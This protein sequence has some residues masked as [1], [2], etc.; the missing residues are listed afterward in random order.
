MSTDLATLKDRVKAIDPRFDAVTI[1][2]NDGQRGVGDGV[3]SCWGGNITDARLVAKDGGVL[4]FVRPSNMDE[5]LGVTTADKIMLVDRDGTQVTAQEVLLNLEERAKYMGYKSV[6]TNVKNPERVVVR[7]QNVWIPLDANGTERKFVPAHYSYQTMNKSNPRNLIVLGTPSGT[8]VH[9]DDS[10]I[11][12]LY[13][14]TEDAEGTNNHWFV[15]QESELDVGQTLNVDDTSNR[16]APSPKKGRFVEMGIKGMGRRGNCFV[17]MSIPNTQKDEPRYSSGGAAA[18]NGTVYRSLC[19]SE[20]KERNC[21]TDGISKAAI[22]SAD[23]TNVVSKAS[24]NEIDIVRPENEPIVITIM[25]YNT[26]KPSSN[27]Q[28]QKVAV[29]TNDVKIAVHEMNKIYDMCDAKC[30][31]SELRVM[32]SKMTFQESFQITHKILHD[33][34]PMITDTPAADADDPFKPNPNALALVM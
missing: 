16:D 18:G 31:L 29:S 21:I 17:V 32:L 14:H 3:L 27:M 8:Y 11:N 9:S 20:S 33:P 26:V 19:F 25:L 24:K 2:W 34:A 12:H 7:V 15:A 4:P 30:K 22:I 23:T 13:S 6:K 5:M 1:A 28:G 10:G